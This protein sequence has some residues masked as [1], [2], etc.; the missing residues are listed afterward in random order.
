MTRRTNARI[1]G[2]AYLLYV[3]AGIASMNLRERAHVNAVLAVVMSFCAL[4]LGVTLFALTKDED[5]DLALV[6]LVCRAIEAMPGVSGELY[7]AVGSTIFA[8]L[9]L[10]G[11]M[12]PASLAWLGFVSS[13]FLVALQVLQR[14][15]MFGGKTDWSSPVTF[16][17]WMPLAVFEITFAIWLLVKGVAPSAKTT[18]HAA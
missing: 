8:W 14:G 5:P 17:I 15:G 12:I 4:L 9:L 13:A 18:A 10:R 3:V 11:R 1:A 16:A 7:F 6:A 2:I